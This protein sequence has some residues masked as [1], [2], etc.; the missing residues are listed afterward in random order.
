MSSS[1]EEA[2][3]LRQRVEHVLNRLGLKRNEKKGQWV[4]VQVVEHLG[5]E[6]D[7]KEGVFRVTQ[8]Q[9]EK[10]ASKA[11]DLLCETS[12]ERRWVPVRKL[13]A[14]N[15]L[16]QSVYLAVPAARLYLRELYFVLTKK[17]SWGAKVKL[18]RQSFGD[19]K[20]WKRLQ[21]Q[22]N[23]ERATDLELREEGAGGTVVAPYW[24]GQSWFRE[25]EE[26]AKEVTSSAS[27]AARPVPA[28]GAR[29][30]VYWPRDDDCYKGTVSD[31]AG[32]GQH[33]IQYDDEDKEWL[34]L[35]EELTRPE[36]LEAEEDN[37]VA[38][39]DEWTSAL[40]ER[41][42]GELGVSRFTVQ[43][44][45]LQQAELALKETTRGNYGPKSKKF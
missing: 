23:V 21:A 42:R 16:C 38:P 1:E 3:E 17:R 25:L 27:A 15:R 24:P 35:S 45:A 2:Y 13:A 43:M 6:V 32:T 39:V 5:L 28:G 33:H 40:R 22:C 10:I 34:Q 26:I 30:E 31:V 12:Q 44:Q 14:F 4:P 19:L 29:L 18:T 37:D 9:F 36:R 7:F 20:W 11:T 41:W 8:A